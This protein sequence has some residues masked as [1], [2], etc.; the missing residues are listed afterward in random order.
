MRRKTLIITISLHALSLMVVFVF[1]GMVFPYLRIAGLSPLLLPLLS[2][3]VA[4]YAGRFAGGVIG[5]FAGILCDISLNEPVGA[6]TILLTFTGLVIGA[7]ADSVITRGFVTYFMFCI[8]VLVLAALIQMF[9]LI[10][11]VGIPPQALLMTALW[12]TIYS[13]VFAFPIWV[14]IRAVWRWISR[15]P[16]STKP[17]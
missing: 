2:T 3:G 17:Q 14:L 12:Q 10:Y 11:I 16:Q 5:I 6:F 4:V 15:E 9:P 13:L 7:L 8:C 1:Q